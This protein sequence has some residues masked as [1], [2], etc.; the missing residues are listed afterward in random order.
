M[1]NRI[2]ELFGD[3]QL[4]QKIQIREP[5]KVESWFMTHPL[6]SERLTNLNHTI[7][8]VQQSQ[9]AALNRPIQRNQYIR[10]LEGLAVGEW[11][12]QE[13]IKGDY[14][15][16]KEFMVKIKLPE[17][18]QGQITNKQYTAVFGQPKKDFYVYFNVEPL[19]VPLSSD[20]YFRV[21]EDKLKRSGLQKEG[22]TS[23]ALKHSG[24]MGTY[25]GSS[26]QLGAIKAVAFAFTKEANGYSL[27][28]I[29]KS[30]DFS[31]FRPLAESM[32]NN[33]AFISSAE[34]LKLQ[35]GRLKIHEVKSGETWDGITA[36]YF[37]SSQGKNKL[38]EYNGLEVTQNPS[39][40]MLVKIPPSLHFQ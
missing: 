11:N 8:L 27:V 23:R 35:P 40:G 9:P 7:S 34:A 37:G 3:K 24:L 12:G 31:A 32:T 6:T 4:I 19:R 21:F 13:L 29:C 28:G 25:K 17:G 15:Y 1:D 36:K 2:S 16:N 26:S 38:A 20:D 39:P 10:R 18:W 5:T 14:Y 22:S 30:A 33:L